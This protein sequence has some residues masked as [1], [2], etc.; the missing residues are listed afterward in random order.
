MDN[1]KI[2]RPIFTASLLIIFLVCIPLIVSPKAGNRAV[3]ATFNFITSN[4]GVV[5]LWAGI[6]CLSFLLWV[7]FSRFG[8]IKLGDKE[9]GPKFS[10]YSWVSMLFCAG[11]A[12]GILYWGTIE[13]VYYYESPP[14][15]ILPHSGEAI[16]WASTYGMFHWGLTGWSF[17]ALPAVAIA[18]FYYVRKIPLFRISSA[19][20]G[21]IHHRAD[22]MLGKFID[23]I[24]MVGMLGSA[25]TSLGFGTPM[26]SAGI[27]ALLGIEESFVLNLFVALFCAVI[28][29]ISVYLGLQKGIKHLSNINMAMAL[30]ILL[31]ILAVGPT[32]FILKMGTNSIGVMFQNFIR[33]NTWTDP[34]TNSGFVEGWTIF[35]WAWWI[36]VGPFMGIFI[37]QIS[38]GRTI[39][40]VILGPLCFGSFG[41]A[42]Y[43]VILGNYALHLELNDILSVTD[44][45]GERGAPAAIIAVIASLPLS[46]YILLLFCLVSVIFLATTYDS[47]SYALASSASKELKPDQ[48]PA[49]WHRLF[50]AFALAF[51]PITLMFIG[52]LRTGGLESP[53][54]ES[55]KTASLV[56]SLPLMVV[57]VVIALS[58]VKSLKEDES[59]RDETRKKSTV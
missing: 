28:F 29:S 57:F 43:Y 14:F 16:E 21:I 23:V 20:R 40:Q 22:G 7:S 55:V 6:A 45:L 50:W 31:F 36:A 59:R 15:G 4:L 51:L 25:G 58:L 5:Y 52:D 35:Y 38:K 1:A 10:T 46:K 30:L 41:C 32:L 56:V 47:A 11:V 2:D 48:S 33:M 13:W 42:I 44:T 8:K 17:Y 34:L 19:C 3:N 9:A 53:G 54:L 12:T 27:S 37:A 49:R 39:R 18:Y 24:F 26:I